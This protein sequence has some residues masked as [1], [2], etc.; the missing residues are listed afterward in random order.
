MKD[1]TEAISIDYDPNV[2]S[3]EQLLG[4]FWKGHRCTYTN[5]SVQYMNAVF[6]QNDSQRN[7]AQKSLEA[8]AIKLNISTPGIK[9]KILPVNEF[10]YAEGYHQKYYL[11]SSSGIRKFLKETY[12]D[13]KSLADSSVAS[14]LNAYLNNGFSR[15]WVTFLEELPSYGLPEEIEAQLRQRATGKK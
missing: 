1:H 3:Y 8:H 7:L 10:T 2:I 5:K 9:T 13:T 15:N 14:R 11:P 4:Y 12:P 6:Y